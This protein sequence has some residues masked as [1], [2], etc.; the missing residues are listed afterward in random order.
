MPS[1]DSIKLMIE[2]Y[3]RFLFVSNVCIYLF[4]KKNRIEREENSFSPF[5]KYFNDRKRGVN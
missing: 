1:G 2:T 3:F 4:Y 5:F